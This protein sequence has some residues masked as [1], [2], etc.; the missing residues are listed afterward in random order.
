MHYSYNYF[1]NFNT[2][3]ESVYDIIHILIRPDNDTSL[4]LIRQLKELI[5]QNF[6]SKLLD[7]RILNSILEH[8]EHI[9]SQNNQNRNEFL[10]II[11][12]F[13]EN[14]I[15]FEDT[16]NDVSFVYYTNLITGC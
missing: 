3:P 8:F 2:F 4:G 13:A 11:G 10:V 7:K 14:N 6:I 15:G 9:K 1:M 12:L 5:E 16:E